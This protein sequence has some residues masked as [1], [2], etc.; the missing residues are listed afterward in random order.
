MLEMIYDMDLELAAQ[1]YA[2]QCHTTGSAI[3]TRPLFGE[4]FHIISSRTIN[5]LDATV[6]AIKAW[7]SQIFHNGVNMQMLYT[8]TLHT[9]QQSPNKFTQAS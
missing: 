5:Y 4:N 7:W 3:S 1:A 9:K 2:D 8:V 6:A